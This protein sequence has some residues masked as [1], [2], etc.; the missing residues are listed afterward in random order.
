MRAYSDFIIRGMNLQS[1]THYTLEKPNNTIVITYMARRASAVWPER[2]YCSENTS[3]F[4]C[5]YWSDERWGTRKHGRMVKNDKEVMEAIRD[6]YKMDPNVIVRD[7][8]YNLL[9]FKEQIKMD[10]ETD[11]MVSC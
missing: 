6:E 5:Q 2:R 9:S 4:K 7:V 1:L 8:D 3:Y 10:L 11:I